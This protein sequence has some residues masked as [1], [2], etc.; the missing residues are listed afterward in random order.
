MSEIEELIQKALYKDID[1]SEEEYREKILEADSITKGHGLT[2]KAPISESV[3]HKRVQLNFYATALNFMASLLG[4]ITTLT[5]QNA[6]LLSQNAELI[7]AIK[8]DTNG[9][10]TTEQCRD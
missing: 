1:L 6:Y 7:K 2:K 8:G 10:H 9:R 4:E 5:Q 3:R